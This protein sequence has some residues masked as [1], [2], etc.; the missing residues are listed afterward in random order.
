M[1]FNVMESPEFSMT[2]CVRCSAGL[3]HDAVKPRVTIFESPYMV[4]P[5][6][7]VRG[8]I[9]VAPETWTLAIDMCLHIIKFEDGS[10]L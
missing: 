9:A 8:V 1:P 5:L 7:A 10:F 6:N 4:E 2:I 3:P